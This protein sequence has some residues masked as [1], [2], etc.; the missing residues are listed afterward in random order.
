MMNITGI[1]GTNKLFYVLIGAVVLIVFLGLIFMLGNFGGGGVVSQA[2]LEFWGVY[3]DR[4]S[5]TKVIE[6]FQNSNQANQNIKI[7]YRQFSYADYEKALIEAL[8]AGA[9][10]DLVMIHN[11]WLAKHRDKL[12]PMPDSSG[13]EEIKFLTLADYQTQL[14]DVAYRDLVFQNKIYGIPL[15]VDT[16]ALYYNKDM[17]NTAGITRPPQNWEEFN[18]DV[19]LLTKFDQSGNIIQAG[20]AIGT[21]KNINRST[22]ILAALMIQN[23]TKMT[24]ATNTAATFTRSVNGVKVGDNA[25]QYYTDF[26][27]SQKT[28]YTWNESQHYSIDAFIEGRVAMMFNY[29]H[30]IPVVRGRYERLN[31]AVASMPQFS[32]LDSKNYANYWGV[33]VLTKSKNQ[34]AAWRFLNFLASKNGSLAYVTQAERPSA[35][36]DIIDMQRND[37]R[38]G[39]FAVQALSAKS[40]YQ[41]DDTAIEQ[42][43]ADM[44]DDVNYKRSKISAALRAAESKISTLMTKRPY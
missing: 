1:L 4:K 6:A 37:P 30:Q 19:E 18:R 28:V 38:L 26:A 23:G 2:K 33:G 35:R 29:S 22:D 10:P 43:F 36:R 12:S 17:F 42:I 40:W 3:E 32:E 7:N 20:A 25:I 8:A 27:N 41:I 16:L 39:V 13:S 21:V 15:Y 31:F 14:V 11:T 44:I 24:N 9:G 34:Q 5:F